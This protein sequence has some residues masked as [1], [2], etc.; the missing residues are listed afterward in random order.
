MCRK[1]VLKPQDVGT[2]AIAGA[3]TSDMSIFSDD[4]VSKPH[5]VST[6]AMAAMAGTSRSDMSISSDDVILMKEDFDPTWIKSVEQE[7]RE[8]FYE[9]R[10]RE[11]S[12]LIEFLIKQ[13]NEI[14]MQHQELKK[15]IDEDR[16]NTSIRIY[17]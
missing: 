16:V 9:R 11:S 10:I 14:W 12:N 7:T 6:S 8:E 13:R 1:V 4:V 3:S 15:N 17:L 2:S 5:D